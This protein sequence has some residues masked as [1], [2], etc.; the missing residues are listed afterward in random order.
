M[1]RL[2]PVDPAKVFLVGHS[3]GAMRALDAAQRLP[4]KIAGVAALGGGRSMR[5]D[6][7]TRKIAFFVAAGKEDFALG[8]TRVLGDILR[9]AEVARLRYHEYDD[10]EHLLVV[11]RA[12]PDVFG[13][14]DDVCRRGKAKE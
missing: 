7:Q 9:K 14:W 5:V 4:G 13:L 10:I 12:L 3:M 1:S 2:Y 6:D 11:Q 8:G